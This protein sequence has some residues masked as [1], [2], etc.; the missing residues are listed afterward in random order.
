MRRLRSL[1]QDSVR[2]GMGQQVKKSLRSTL[3][4]VLAAVA[5]AGCFAPGEHPTSGAGAVPPGLYHLFD[6]SQFCHVDKVDGGASLPMTL[7]PGDG[8]RYIDVRSTDAA[9]DNEGCLLV[10]AD[11]PWDQKF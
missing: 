3:L 4:L 1:R 11:S 5:L 6:Y 10:L 2:H 8:P 9:I 7:V